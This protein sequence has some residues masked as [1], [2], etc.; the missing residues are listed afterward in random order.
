[1]SLPYA[2]CPNEECINHGVNAFEHW[3]QMAD[4][5]LTYRK[6]RDHTAT[7]RQCQ[8]PVNL[9]TAR[10]IEKTRQNKALWKAILEGARTQRPV[11]DTIELTRIGTGNYYRYL[12]RMGAR[13]RDYHAYRNA[14]LLHPDVLRRAKPIA[15]YTDVLDISLK[16][17]R[18]DRRHT[19]LK[20]ILTAAPVGETIY[21][22][23]AHPFFLPKAFAADDETLAADRGRL[24]ADSRWV[25]VLHPQTSDVTMTTDQNIEAVPDLGRGGYFLRS[26]Y[27]ELA[28]F[29]V[30]QKLLSRFRTIHNYM[31][32]AK[33]M[34]PAA[35]VA[36]RDRILAGR[37]DPDG[38]PPATPPDTAEVVLFQHDKKTKHKKSARTAARAATVEPVTES[39]LT[40]AWNAAEK[41]YKALDV[42]KEEPLFKGKVNRNDPRV[43]AR[44]FRRSLRGAY[45]KNDDNWAWLHYP[46]QS[47]AFYRPRTLWLTR[48]P[49]KSYGRHDKKLLLNAT[50]QPVDSIFN[51]VRARTASAGRPSLRAVGRSFR[52]SYVLPATALSE[53]SVYLVFRNYAL[54]YKTEQ[55]Q[56]PAEEM[57][58]VI[59]SAAELDVL[60]RAWSFRLGVTH[61]KR[62]TRWL[63]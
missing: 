17:F 10:G 14:R 37:P 24:D 61:A 49:G 40:A 15:L 22:V 6:K 30:V 16:A 26:P 27:A 63:K 51:S 48:M 59:P 1:M 50:L 45:A 41:R 19:F 53:L 34:F 36:Y 20:V 18:E 62:I 7:C 42:S 47:P 35:L 57:G 52:E 33:D 13:L 23:A 31:D 25:S 4:R 38:E 58:L 39:G 44:Q 8:S 29:L 46:P 54:R 2:D 28:H 11:T 43:K 3:E 5:T 32:S 12:D 55:T 56:I 21:V 9:G 60:D